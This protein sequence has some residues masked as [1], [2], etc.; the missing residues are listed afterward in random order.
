VAKWFFRHG[1]LP[2]VVLAALDRAP[3]NGYQLLG[4]LDRLFGD[5]YEPSTGS[6]YPAI[7]ALQQEGLVTGSPH[8]PR[9]VQVLELTDTGRDALRRRGEQL[10]AL[11]LRTGAH[12]RA[13]GSLD[14]AIDEFAARVRLLVPMLDALK[15]QELLESTAS[16]LERLAGQHREA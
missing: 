3:M 8:G 12:I 16:E 11:E 4:E 6:V 9:N 7:R 2:L 15:A 5:A 13:D 14:S 1:E 10:A